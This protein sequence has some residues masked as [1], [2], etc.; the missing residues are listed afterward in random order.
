MAIREISK[1]FPRQQF[2]RDYW[3]KEP[4]VVR[5]WFPEATK[6]LDADE[7]AGMA[8]ESVIESRLV[9]QA[10]THQSWHVEHGPFAAERLQ[11]LPRSAWSLLVQGVERWSPPVA[12]MMGHFRFIRD[13]RID[14]V[15]VSFAPE[16]SG[17]GAHWDRYDVFLIQGKGQ[18]RWGLS[19]DP[20]RGDEAL[21]EGIDLKILQDFLP[22]H[23]IV[24][25]EGDV[26]YVPP[27]FAHHGVSV[28]DA[29]TFSMGFRSPNL[30]DMLSSY[31]GF[32]A[33]SLPDDLLFA[34]PVDSVAEHPAL[35]ARQDVER[36]RQALLELLSDPASFD[37]W[38]G[39]YLTEPKLP[40]D[41][42]ESEIEVTA[43]DLGRLPPETR[44]ER[45]EGRRFL[46]L[47][48]AQGTRQL[49]VEGEEY[50]LAARCQAL[51]D[52]LARELRFSWKDLRAL[53]QQE[54][55]AW[56]VICRLF[57]KGILLVEDWQQ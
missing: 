48:S 4:V 34:D 46:L 7:L 22:D 20:L 37:S 14:D 57:S 16:G 28:S 30:V 40:S 36:M 43:A 24:L 29:L 33:Q 53:M 47:P 13:W 6:W 2:M 35:I 54:A 3:Q 45:C 23:E 8:C 50:P 55:S 42:G 26:L 10:N 52:F 31:S 49:F 44:I 19:A 38:L 5:Q 25:Q 21:L 41:G 9:L 39:S 18:R 51:A 1:D 15:M 27:M 17:I 11:N 56:A 12:A 32:R